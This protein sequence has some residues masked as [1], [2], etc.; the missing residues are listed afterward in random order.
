MAQ[1]KLTIKDIAKLAQVSPSSVSMVIN[2][3]EGLSEATK[4]RILRTIKESNYYPTASSQRLVSRKSFNI[5]FIYPIEMSPFSDFFYNEVARGLVEELTLN[6]FNVVF[7][8][9]LVS[10]GIIEIPSIINKRDA[11]AAILMHDAPQAILDRLDELELPFILLDWQRET[12]GCANLDLDN[13]QSTYRAVNYLIQMG[14]TKI[15]LLGSERQPQFF[16]RCFN[17]YRKALDE[18]QLPVYTGW[19]QSSVYDVDS[20]VST[21][22]KLMDA[23]TQ[24]T[25]VCCTNDYIA[26]FALKAAAL[27]NISVPNELSFIGKDDI[28]VSSYIYPGLTTVSYDKTKIGKETAH[29]LLRMLKGEIVGDVVM[30]GGSIIERKSV[31]MNLKK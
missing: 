14:H 25:A 21:I 15:A 12:H 5:P 8:P 28:S 13:Q 4:E 3:R 6:D 29:M 7:V 20:A 23:E 30:G 24:P 10:D 16:L 19:I 17:G 31:A 2:G 11:D 18:A 1:Q 26:I 27:L 9:L 22:K